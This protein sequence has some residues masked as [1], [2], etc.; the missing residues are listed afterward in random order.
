VIIEID[1][2]SGVPVARQIADAITLRALSGA[3]EPGSALPD[4]RE[5]SLQLQ[6]NP[7]TVEQTYELLLSE[8][9]AKRAPSDERLVV[10]EPPPEVAMP[11]REAF[12]RTLR[13]L[14][15]RARRAGLSPDQLR[16]TFEDVME[17]IDRGE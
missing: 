13:G 5:L 6:V 16:R 4:V 10:A 14:L 3:L 2:R 12:A 8:G 11:A 15:E 17:G 9:V 1:F 7:N